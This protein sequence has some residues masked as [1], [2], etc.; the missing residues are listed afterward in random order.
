MEKYNLLTRELLAAGFSAENHPTYVKVAGGCLS[1]EDP[2][3]NIYGGFEYQRVYAD[4]F[5]YKTG[6]GLFVQGMHVLDDI[7]VGGC[8]H[9]HE[10]NNPVVRCPYLKNGCEKN[11]DYDLGNVV[12]GGGLCAQCWCECHRTDE[13][14]NYN[15]SIERAK[16]QDRVER[17]RLFQELVKKHNGRI[18]RN[19]CSFNEH[20]GEWIFDYNPKRCLIGCPKMYGY[21]DVLGKQLSKKKGNVFFDIKKEF[22]IKVRDGDQI[23]L[24]DKSHYVEIV[25]GFK[26]FKN[27]ISIDICEAYA[28]LGK[29]EILQ[30]YEMNHSYEKFWNDTITFEVLNIRAEAKET[31]DLL[32]DLEDI[33]NGIVISHESDN[34]AAK[35]DLKRERAEKAKEAKRKKF[36]KEIRARGWNALDQTEKK[37]ALKVLEDYEI[38]EADREFRKPK[39]EPKESQISIFDFIGGA[40]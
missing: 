30:N 40:D 16:E 14:Y 18:C 38:K 19:Q 27:P 33:K 5:V 37:N 31:R 36:T 21:C 1:K 24:F 29:K 9:S 6:C 7:S 32:Q 10:N 3:Y 12:Y 13:T 8:N 11:F 23:G 25:K 35:K 34:I 39:E 17:E 26:V 22:D 28:R 4:K 2:L 20:T 15:N